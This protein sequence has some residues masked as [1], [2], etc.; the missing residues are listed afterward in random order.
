MVN[1]LSG[2]LTYGGLIWLSSRVLPEA[3]VA[4]LAVLHSFVLINMYQLYDV[5]LKARQADLTSKAR[6]SLYRR[7]NL[8][9][10]LALP[11]LFVLAGRQALALIGNPVDIGLLETALFGLFMAFEMGNLFVQSIT[12]VNHG[13]V[14]R[15]HV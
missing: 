6:R 12:Q 10:M 7:L 13:L 11:P 14:H 5:F 15:L 3:Q 9:F 2:L 4:K 1:T 8:L